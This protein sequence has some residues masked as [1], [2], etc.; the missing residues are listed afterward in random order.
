M[1]KAIRIN[2][3]LSNDA[4][5]LIHQR[6]IF[7]GSVAG[8]PCRISHLASDCVRGINRKAFLPEHD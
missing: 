1:T 6:T 7:R 2:T 4:G 5:S 3:F 8:D